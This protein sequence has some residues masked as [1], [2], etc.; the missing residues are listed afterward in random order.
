MG[1]EIERKFLVDASKWKKVKPKKGYKIIQGYL[2]KSPEKTIRVRLKDEH[3]YLTIKGKTKGISRSEFEYEIPKQEA[4][5]LLHQFCDKKIIKNR[6]ELKVHEFVWEIDEFTSP[7]P[8]LILAEIELSHEK[9]TFVRPEW[10]GEEVSHL[11]EYFN[12]NMI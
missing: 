9:E 2:L 5:D 8:G 12:S 6:Y 11:T 7:K 4:E 3:G 10:L 1:V